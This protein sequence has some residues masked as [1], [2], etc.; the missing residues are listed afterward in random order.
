MIG[1][2][3]LQARLGWQQDRSQQLAKGLEQLKHAHQ[4][5]TD[6]TERYKQSLA[7]LQRN[8]AGLR[9]RLLDLMKKVELVR[10]MNIPMQPDEVKLAQRLVGLSKQVD[11]V[12]KMMASQQS[13]TIPVLQ[14]HAVEIPNRE[15]LFQIFQG[16]RH[17]LVELSTVVQKD[18]RDVKLLQERLQ[19][20]HT[21]LHR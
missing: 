14:P 7:L 9:Q 17:N 8:H 16:Q 12:N 11:E 13:K 1:A 3:A 2:E 6:Q 15:A 4:A 18:R 5:L 10:C 19:R 21:P 20:Q